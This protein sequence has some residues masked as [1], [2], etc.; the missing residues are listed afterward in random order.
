[1]KIQFGTCRLINSLSST[2]VL[3]KAEEIAISN[4]SF[5]E[6]SATTLLPIRQLL[7]KIIPNQDMLLVA[8][9]L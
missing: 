2:Q 7:G 9:G 6:A 8:P 3:A 4:L 1:M 5:Q